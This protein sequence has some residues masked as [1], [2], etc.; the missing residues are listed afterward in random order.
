MHIWESRDRVNKRSLAEGCGTQVVW[1]PVQFAISVLYAD[2]QGWAPIATLVRMRSKS[3]SVPSRP[4]CKK[5]PGAGGVY[6]VMLIWKTRS[7]AAVVNALLPNPLVP[8]V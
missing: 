7:P 4:G 3:T 2:V 5:M 6:G 8:E 1:L